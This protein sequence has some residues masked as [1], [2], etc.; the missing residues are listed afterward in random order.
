M[1]PQAPAPPPGRPALLPHL[2]KLAAHSAVY[3]AADVW[4]NLVNFLLIPVYTAYLSPTEYGHL[5][6]LQLFAV[7]A[8]ILFRL[9]LDAGFFR[10]H[11][12]METEDQRRRLAGTVAVFSAGVAVCLFALVALGAGP[13]SRAVLGHEVPSRWWVVLVAGDIFAGTFA[14]VPLNLLRI[15]NRPALFSVYNAGRQTLNI[16]LKVAFVALGY[17]VTGVLWSDLVATILFSLALLPILFRHAGLAFDRGLLREVLAFALPKVPHGLLV[18]TLNLAD[19]RILLLFVSRAEVGLYAVGYTFGTLPKFA[20]SAFEP[21]WGP[22]MYSEIKREG[23]KETLARVTTYVFAVFAFVTLGAAVLG[24]EA[25]T[26]MTPKNPA[27]RAAAPVI[28]VV[29]LAYLFHGAFLLTSIGLAIERKAVRYYPVVTAIAAATNIA[30]NFALV[31]RFG[32]MGAA[33]ATVAGYAVMAGLGWGFSHRLYPIPFEG[34]RLAL[35][36]VSAAAIWA[37][38]TRAPGALFP[39]IVVKALLLVLYGALLAAAALLGRHRR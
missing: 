27:F 15:Q 13:L 5:A 36:A 1:S 20:L 4:T 10:V 34:R 29:A 18:Q 33:W 32:M 38:S 39:A 2:K 11:Y 3:G 22:F 14:F 8:K 19:R 6:L 31:P 16:V 25:L 12:E 23:A 30:L 21:A 26:V 37:V 9:G 17:G 7:M 28:P 35:V 24:R